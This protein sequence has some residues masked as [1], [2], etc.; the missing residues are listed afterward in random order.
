MS[1]QSAGTFIREARRKAGLTQEQLAEGICAPSSLS[2]IE[3]GACGVSPSTFRSLVEKTGISAEAFPTFV[4]RT[5]FD[6]FYALK[7]AR[8]YLDSWFLNEAYK[9][10][11]KLYDMKCSGNRFH[12]QEWLLLVCYLQ[13]RSGCCDYD[14]VRQYATEAIDLSLPQFDLKQIDS[15]FLSVNEIELLI[16]LASAQLYLGHSEEVRSLCM[17]LTE[18][19]THTRY[20]STQKHLLMAENAIVYTKYLL[21]S[22]LY[23]QAMETAE[24]FRLLMIQESND[25][26]LYELTFLLCLANYHIGN[27][28]AALQYFK[29]CFYSAHSAGSCY[30]TLCRRYILEHTTLTISAQILSLPDI[31]VKS[32]TFKILTDTSLH[33]GICD[34]SSLQLYQLG[35][36]I[37][38][39]RTEQSITQNTLCQGLCSKSTLSKIESNTQMPDA[40][41]AEALLQRLGISDTVFTFFGNETETKLHEL[42]NSLFQNFSC[43]HD[44]IAYTL[45]E[46]EQALQGT[47]FPLYR[48]YLLYKKAVYGRNPDQNISMLEEALAVTLPNFSIKHILHYRLTWNE[49]TIINNLAA[50]YNENGNSTVAVH[51]LYSIMEYLDENQIDVLLAKRIKTVVISMLSKL[52]YC[53]EQHRELL[54]LFSNT[55]LFPFCS[56]YYTG[57]FFGNLFQSAGFQ[58]DPNK[59]VYAAYSYYCFLLTNHTL[60]A[61]KVDKYLHKNFENTVD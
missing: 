52:L 24:H 56:T 28:E 54:C 29:T 7:R 16:C 43:D 59:D 13:L 41:L 40:S 18:Y 42:K 31:P 6:C 60:L 27:E 30:A 50:A 53:I 48:Q 8:F 36:L 1:I 23:P 9:E 2:S 57:I 39:L 4:D 12:Y 49:L 35:N 15:K 37:H 34:L 26:C 19:L 33:N 20:D 61:E 10:L 22:G 5:D 11:E 21:A 58:N 45:D 25:T 3:R 14:T 32:Y 55:T 51:Y 38:D 47:D 17:Q 46:L 44:A